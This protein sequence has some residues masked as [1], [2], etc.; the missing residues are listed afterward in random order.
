MRPSVSIVVLALTGALVSCGSYDSTATIAMPD[1]PFSSQ[2]PLD[3]V[4]IRSTGA[5]VADSTSDPSGTFEL[6][7]YVE[8][9][10]PNTPMFETKPKSGSVPSQVLD[11]GVGLVVL[12]FSGNYMQVQTEKGEIGYVAKLTV[13][14]QGVSQSANASDA[15]IVL[16]DSEIEEIADIVSGDFSTSAE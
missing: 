12:G 14:P 10:Q 4:S 1:E 2:S 6:G 7:D 15:T 3:L 9:I 16:D 11:Q 8:T 13:A 5:A